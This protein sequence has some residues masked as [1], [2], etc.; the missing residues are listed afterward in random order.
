MEK[1]ITY[2]DAYKLYLQKERYEVMPFESEYGEEGFCEYL[3][4]CGFIIVTGGEIDHE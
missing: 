3:E 4:R 1:L 2:E